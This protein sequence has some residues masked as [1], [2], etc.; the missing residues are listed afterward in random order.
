MRTTIMAAMFLA[1]AFTSPVVA[2]Q[3]VPFHGSLQATETDTLAFPFLTVNL[4][5]TGQATHLGRYTTLFRLQVDLRTAS[6]LGS[7]VLIAANGNSIFGTISGHSTDVG[8]L[9]SIVETATITGGTGRFDDA[10]GS[11]TIERLLDQATG[12]SSGAFNGAIDFYE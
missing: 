5:G 12:N 3:D 6:S 8:D 4:S 9:N 11:F 1:A 2:T 7:F 10:T